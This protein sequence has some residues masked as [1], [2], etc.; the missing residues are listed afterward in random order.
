MAAMHFC[1]V[2]TFYPPYSFG[3]DAIAVQRLCQALARRGHR[4]TVI[5]DLDAYHALHRRPLPPVAEPDDGVEVIRLRSSLG[6]L[7]SLLTHQTGT[8]IVHRRELRRL[9]ESSCLDIINFHNVSLIGGPGVL[10]FGRAP[11]L[12]TAHEHWLVCPTHVLWRHDRE[13]CTA[14][15]CLRCVANFHRPPQLWRYG[16]SLK[17]ASHHVEAFIAMSEFSRLKHHEFGFARDMEVIP[18]FISDAAIDARLGNASADRGRPHH[19]PYFLIV[20]RLERIKGVDSIL[21]VFGR[22]PDADLLIA[23]DGAARQ[24]LEKQASDNPRIHFLGQVAPSAL[25]RYYANA[26]ALIVPSVGYETFG[27]ILIE[28]FLESTPVIARRIGPF[29]EMVERSEAGTTFATADELVVRMQELQR[30]PVLR[31]RLGMQGFAAVRRYWSERVVIPKY[32]ALAEAV[33]QGGACSS[34]G[35]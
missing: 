6:T 11:K 19:R 1:H 21:P 28:S 27:L 13:P 20:G 31:R 22:Y 35:P 12:Y 25:A 34:S 33:S 30:D 26:I 7:S 3:G 2:T 16:D 32:I 9:L 10:A 8:P 18:G 29:P 23:G 15:Q 24:S 17:R 4:V 5:S 14:R